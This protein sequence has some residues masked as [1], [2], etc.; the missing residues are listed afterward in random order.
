[1]EKYNELLAQ[2]ADME[3]IVDKTAEQKAEFDKTKAQVEAMGVENARQAGIYMVCAEMGV[4]DETRVAFLGDKT[5]DAQALKDKLYID[6]KSGNMNIANIEDNT[7]GIKTG[8]T[9]ALEMQA[10]LIVET[11]NAIA[12][13]YQGATLVDMSRALI[14]QDAPMDIQSVANII[15]SPGEMGRM[16]M[17]TDTLPTLLVN[18]GRRVVEKEAQEARTMY[19]HISGVTKTPDFK[20]AKVLKIG[21]MGLLNPHKQGGERKRGEF[22]EEFES[23]AIST[24]TKEFMF[25]REMIYNSDVFDIMK[26]FRDAGGA[27][28]K[29]TDAIVFD[30]MTGGNRVIDLSGYVMNDGLPIFHADHGNLGS[31][32]LSSASLTAARLAMTKHVLID[33]TAAYITPDTLVIGEELR[34]T[35]EEILK[36]AASIADNKN[37]SV[38]NTHYNSLNLVISPLINGVEW[39]MMDSTNGMDRL[40]LTA[41]NGKPITTLIR[42]D[43]LEAVFKIVHD[44]GAFAKDYRGLYKG[45]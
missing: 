40:E 1:M 14:G 18:T 20:T 15:M 23:Y 21:G 26:K 31:S 9:Q 34:A 19:R 12:I 35:A 38:Y 2:L 37:A 41:T 45:K 4:D 24:Y 10:G 28:D 29:T 44:T 33:G 27:A 11:P 6:M 30:L 22:N 8:I 17:S 5:K 13:K 32:A 16:G 36:S 42:Q 3:A 43:P 7:V 25:T 39:Y